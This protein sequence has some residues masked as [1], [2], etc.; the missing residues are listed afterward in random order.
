MKKVF[1]YKTKISR[2]TDK[3]KL[4]SKETKHYDYGT[5]NIRKPELVKH[6]GKTVKVKII[7]D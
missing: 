6:M 5:I 2:T 3:K 7:I 4:A 1:E